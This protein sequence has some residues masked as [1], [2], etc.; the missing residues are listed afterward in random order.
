MGFCE[1]LT[2][3]DEQHRVEPAEHCPLASPLLL[4]PSLPLPVRGRTVQLVTTAQ[5][6]MAIDVRM[7]NILF[8]EVSSLA[9]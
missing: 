1:E 4:P 9:V 3:S 2:V 5:A 7:A 6:I 8:I